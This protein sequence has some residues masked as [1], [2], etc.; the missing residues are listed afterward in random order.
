MKSG[1]KSHTNLQQAD[2]PKTEYLSGFMGLVMVLTNRQKRSNYCKCLEKY[3][4]DIAERNP[5]RY[6]GVTEINSAKRRK[7]KTT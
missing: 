4:R 6:F 1:R 7:R 3:S 2:S 5:A